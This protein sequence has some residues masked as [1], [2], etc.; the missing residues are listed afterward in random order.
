MRA[1]RLRE[2]RV[3]GVYW[4]DDSRLYELVAGT[5][6]QCCRCGKWAQSIFRW[7]SERV[8]GEHFRVASKTRIRLTTTFALRVHR[9]GA[10]V[11]PPARVVRRGDEVAVAGPPRRVGKYDRFDLPCGGFVLAPRSRW[12]WV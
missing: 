10:R 7:G 11:L 8:C 6:Q 4:G 2:T 3:R 5:E 9:E 1:V 12:A